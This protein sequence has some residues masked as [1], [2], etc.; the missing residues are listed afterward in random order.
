[1]RRPVLVLAILVVSFGLTLALAD[2]AKVT[3]TTKEESA[4]Q[5]AEAQPAPAT[6]DAQTST[7]ESKTAAEIVEEWKVQVQPMAIPDCPAERDTCA[8]NTTVCGGNNPCRTSFPGSPVDTGVNKCRRSNGQLLNCVPG[9][10][11]VHVTTTQCTQC[12]CCFTQPACF[13][14]NDCAEVIS[15]SCQ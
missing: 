12:P 7:C 4:S 5:A 6:G 14:P 15:L 9:G 11:T 1:M 10:Q 3:P 2:E 13:C 8:G